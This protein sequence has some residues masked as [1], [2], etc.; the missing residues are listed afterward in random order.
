MFRNT[1][2]PRTY[3][4]PKKRSAPGGGGASGQ[5]SKRGAKASSVM[6]KAK[7]VRAVKQTPL[8]V[9][10]KVVRSLAEKKSVNTDPQTYTFNASNATMSAAVDLA[11]PLAAI[12]QGNTDGTRVGN[13]IRLVRYTLKINFNAFYNTGVPATDV[14]LVVQMFIGR[15]KQDPAQLPSSTD[16]GRIYD[17]GSGSAGADGTMLST[18]RDINTEYFNIV[19]YRK[20]KLG[21]AIGT[22]NTYANND[23]PLCQEFVLNDLLKGEVI[24]NDALTPVNKFLYMWCTATRLDSATTSAAPCVC[25]YYI[26][27]QYTDI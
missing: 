8:S 13:R 9:I 26:S 11:A 10:K 6:S 7:G 3:S 19:A 27:C 12:A 4:N 18:L 22:G 2:T 24:F 15:L 25:R 21:I 16:L 23:F 17:D 20:F 5:S 14:P 1:V